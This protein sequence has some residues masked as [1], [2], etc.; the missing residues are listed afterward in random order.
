M[1]A[2]EWFFNELQRMQYFIGND[3]LEAYKEAK[4]M[5]KDQLN[6]ARIDGISLANKGYGSKSTSSQKEISDEEI[7]NIAKECVLEDL[8]TSIDS[9]V[10]GAKMYRETIKIKK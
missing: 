8:I 1:T 6:I 7:L 3:M 5:E 10:L 4:E 9:F 2:V